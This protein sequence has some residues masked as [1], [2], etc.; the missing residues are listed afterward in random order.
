MVTKPQ[1]L[2]CD[3]TMVFKMG[4]GGGGRGGRG[5]T[6]QASISTFQN[7]LFK[8]TINILLLPLH[9]HLPI[10]RLPSR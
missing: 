9:P 5:E 1:I 6:P 7:L 4:G 10:N 3:M 2:N 8:E